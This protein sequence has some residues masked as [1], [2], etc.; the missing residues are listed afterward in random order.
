MNR[1]KNLFASFCCLFLIMS[2]LGVSLSAQIF[3]PFY[4]DNFPLGERTPPAATDLH[5]MF[6]RLAATARRDGSVKIIVGFQV[7]NYRNDAELGRVAQDKQRGDIK[8][9]QASILDHL[10]DFEIF[11]PKKFDFIPF[12]AMEISESALDVLR[13]SPDIIS[14][15][16]DKMQKQMLP[17]SIPIIGGSPFGG[18]SGGTFGGFSGAGRTVAVLD[19]GVDKFHPFF[20]NRVVSEACYSRTTGTTASVCPGGASSSTA[21]GSGLHCGVAGCT[22]GTHVAGIAAGGNPQIIGN[23]VARHANIIAVQVFSRVTN[24][25]STSDCTISFTGDVISGLERVYALRTTYAIDAVNMSLGGGRYFNYCDAQQPEYKA[26]IDTL[27]AAGI[28][29]IVASGND[30]YTDSIGSPACVSTAF[31]V[32]STND[33]DVYPIDFV[34]TFSNSASFL[35]LLAP[36]ELILSAVPGGGYDNK[37]GT[38]MAAP[39]VAGAWAVMKQKF[40]NDTIAQTYTRLRYSGIQVLDSRN[41]FVKP[42]IKLDTALNTSDVDP[43]SSAMPISF[44]QTINGTL[45]NTDCLLPFGNRADVYAF[46]GT[47]GQ[48]VA[49]SQN[50]GAFFTYLFLVNSSGAIIGQNGN[51]STSRIPAGSGFLTLPATGTYYIYATSVE[52]NRFG[53]YTVSLTTD[54]PSCNFTITSSSQSFTAAGGGGSFGVNSPAGCAWTAQSNAA[55]MTTS[56]TGN[57][58]GTVNYSVAANTSAVQRTGTISTGGQI[59]TVTQAAA[60]VPPNTRRAFDFDG[61]GKTDISIF[62]PS[63]GEWWYLR[64]SDNTN[65]AFQFGAGTDRLVPADFTGDGKTDVAF[66]RPSTGEWFILRSEDNSFY[67]FPFGANGDIPVPADFD[68]D[69]KADPAVF[70]PSTGTWFIQNSGGGTTII[71]FG[72]AT[73]KPVVADYDGDGKADLAIYRPAE[74][75]WWLNRS[76]AGLVVLTFGTANDRTV[77]AD[78]T[79]DGKADIAFWRPATGEWFILRSEDFSFYSFPFGASGDIPVPGDFDGDGR[80]DAAVFRPSNNTWYIS[81]STAGIQ[82]QGFGAS[83]DI[84]VPNAFVR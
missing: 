46:N 23:G 13:Q 36:G 66:W 20:N 64:S 26:I 65:R 67:S 3:K 84:P 83:G 61:D 18:A 70:R 81:R 73:D 54:A 35:N 9:K 79:G 19:T 78:Y 53:N 29:T 75:Q 48:G 59:H 38:S 69:G 17:Q 80:S 2:A 34:S 77:Q 82:I 27:R 50:S 62:R 11:N 21:S 49:V 28:P 30:S 12:M 45:A 72:G 24:C 40:P 58:N 43:C 5:V 14:I 37:D 71:P 25:Q 52:G 47:Q 56:S 39:M 51:G 4:Y 22:H 8:A 74:G 31:S 10:R 33:G 32:G 63:G 15:Q 68:G 7:E 60:V 42:R 6:D 1:I 57:G 76:T 44:G 16:E 55:W 41:G